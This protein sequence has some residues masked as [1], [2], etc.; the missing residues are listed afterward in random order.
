MSRLKV[1]ITT[2]A[3][4]VILTSNSHADI[5]LKGGTVLVTTGDPVSKLHKHIKPGKSYS[6]S[7]CKKP[8]NDT[9]SRNT[10]YGTIYEYKMTNRIYI[11]QTYRGTITYV[12]WR[13]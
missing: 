7:V 10:G 8:S 13:R 9:C 3:L 1:T 2:L 11:V 6:G 4:S 5:R 12:E